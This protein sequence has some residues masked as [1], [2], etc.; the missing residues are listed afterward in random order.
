MPKTKTSIAI[1]LLLLL[2]AIK[3]A[4]LVWSVDKGFEMTDEGYYLLWFHSAHLYAP[5]MHLNYYYLVQ[6]LFG[7]VDWDITTMRIGGIVTEVGA[8]LAL[9]WGLSKYLKAKLPELYSPAFVTVLLVGGFA[10]LFTAEHPRSLSYD[11]VTH[12]LT[13]IGG[14]LLLAWLSF[15]EKPKGWQLIVFFAL[16]GVILAAQFIVK[17]S[18]AILLAGLWAS[19]SLLAKRKRGTIVLATLSTL[20][21]MGLLF[22]GLF[23][24]Q[25]SLSTFLEYYRISYERISQLG[26]SPI[27]IVLKTY[28]AKDTV[29]FAL[30]IGPALLIILGALFAFKNQET[31]KSI[32]RAMAL[33]LGVFVMQAF[34][35]P[36]NYFPQWHYRFIDLLLLLII[37]GSYVAWQFTTAGR[38]VFILSLVLF[39]LPFVCAIGSAINWAMSLFS[40]LPAWIMLV[41]VLWHYIGKQTGMRVWAEIVQ[42]SIIIGSFLIFLQVFLYPNYL[43]HG[44][45][46]S[47]AAQTEQAVAYDPIKLDSPTA[48]FVNETEQ[49]LTSNGFKPGNYLLAL[50]DLPG[51]VYLMQ[52]YSPQVPWYFGETTRATVKEAVDNTCWHISEITETNVF[53]VKPVTVHPDVSNCL[54][55]SKINFPTNYLKAGNVYNT[56]CKCEMEVW[57]PK[58]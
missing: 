10:V 15:N 8:V 21:G 44:M 30:N 38:A 32:F 4:I 41:V 58:Q 42:Y 29:H 46:A 34:L 28:L 24:T 2:A 11:S 40:Y 49:L 26:Y 17:F 33:G 54:S 53:V 31:K 36:T 37:S 51:L 14:G 50:Y 47:M 23:G 43:P 45:A 12:L 1:I 27:D 35:F 57:A 19:V 7:W 13:A 48:K 5:D 25:I 9:G 56:Y 18:S 3:L 22:T 16:L 52:G 39:A 6:L 55:S 20:L